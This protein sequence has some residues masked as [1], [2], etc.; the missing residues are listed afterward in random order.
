MLK[1]KM[2]MR[3][4]KNEWT[5]C[6]YFFFPSKKIHE[7]AVVVVLFRLNR[8]IHHHHLILSCECIG[9]SEQ[10]V[11]VLLENHV[12]RDRVS[13]QTSF[14]SSSFLGCIRVSCWSWLLLLLLL[15]LVLH[16]RLEFADKELDRLRLL[17]L[18]LSWRRRNRGTLF[19]LSSRLFGS[20]FWRRGNLSISNVPYTSRF[21]GLFDV[22][23]EQ[24]LGRNIER[25]FPSLCFQS[26]TRAAADVFLVPSRYRLLAFC[27][28][29]IWIEP[30]LSSFGIPLD[31]FSLCFPCEQKFRSTCWNFVLLLFE[32]ASIIRVFFFFAWT[33]TLFTLVVLKRV[34]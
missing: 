21:V 31:G 6:C 33:S 22:S 13:I 7:T 4:K 30:R 19:F 8:R 32:I 28:N 23:L 12:V 17:L 25:F 10:V 5:R 3:T 14:G 2:R 9:L 34:S 16:I 26:G 27:K 15:R 29:R 20:G 1:M 24:D 11:V 18:L